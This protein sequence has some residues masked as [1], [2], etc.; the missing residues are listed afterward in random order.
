M[1]GVPADKLNGDN[2]EKIS[3]LELNIKG[4]LYGQDETVEQ[5]LE[6]VYVSFAGIGNETKPTASFIF[7][8]PTGTGKC[9]SGDQEV[10]V[11][12]TDDM[13]NFAKEYH[14]L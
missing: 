8:G 2:Y 10:T 14:L 12:M 3:K 9:L 11:Q 1:T 13:Y 5:V 6:R 7:L 4:K